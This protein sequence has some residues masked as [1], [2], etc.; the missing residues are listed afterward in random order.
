MAFL[1]FLVSTVFISF[2]Y[3][4][5]FLNLFFASSCFLAVQ[6]LFPGYSWLYFF[7]YLLLIFPFFKFFV[8]LRSIVVF[9]Q[10]IPILCILFY[11]VSYRALPCFG[12]MM[13][14]SIFLWVYI[15]CL[16]IILFTQNSPPFSIC[17]TTDNTHTYTP[18]PATHTR[19]KSKIRENPHDFLYLVVEARSKLNLNTLRKLFPKPKE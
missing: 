8:L 1:I 10:G 5:F 15:H 4:F 3:V 6:L 7:I 13:L 17:Y 9:M 16:Y 2:F 19:R 18:A 11:V 14:F 12:V